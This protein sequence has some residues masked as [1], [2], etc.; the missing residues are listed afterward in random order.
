MARGAWNLFGTL[1]HTTSICGCA[2][3]ASTVKAVTPNLWATSRARASDRSATP[4]K[5]PLRTLAAAAARFSP[6]DPT[7]TTPTLTIIKETS[8][9]LRY[10]AQCLGDEK[11]DAR[12]VGAVQG[13]L[14]VPHAPFSQRETTKSSGRQCT[15]PQL[16]VG[17]LERQGT[18]QTS[19][20]QTWRDCTPL[21]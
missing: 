16:A 8:T 1:I 18:K 2:N 7:P 11:V 9:F 3:S 21:V 19:R 20:N 12:S 10:R 13:P 4:I 15:T 14:H 17:Y 5:C 6:N